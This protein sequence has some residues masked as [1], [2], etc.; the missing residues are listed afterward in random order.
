MSLTSASAFTK[1]RV[2]ANYLSHPNDLR[3]MIRGVRLGLRIARAPALQG[4]LSLVPHAEDTEDI[5]WPADADPDVVGDADLEAWVRAHAET[6]YHPIGTA[7]IGRDARASVVDPALRVHGVTSLRIVDA[8]VFP[9]QISGHPVSRASV[10][11]L[12]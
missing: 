9:A 3:V 4:M 8:S 5:F 12:R 1:P 11:A 6:L 2:D 7:C 10:L